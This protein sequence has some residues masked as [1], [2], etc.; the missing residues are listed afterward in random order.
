MPWDDIVAR[1]CPYTDR[2]ACACSRSVAQC[3]LACER[4]DCGL[5]TVGAPV[6]ACERGAS[7]CASLISRARIDMSDEE[8][9]ED[10]PA[11]AGAAQTQNMAETLTQGEYCAR[12]ITAGGGMKRRDKEIRKQPSGVPLLVQIPGFCCSAGIPLLLGSLLGRFLI[13]I[14]SRIIPSRLSD[15]HSSRNRVRVVLSIARPCRVC[16][17]LVKK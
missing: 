7:A 5:R 12:Q 14:S 3:R 2:D 8:Q 6:S 10:L 16:R 4:A 9:E 13:S 1:W 11:E 17:G 15:E